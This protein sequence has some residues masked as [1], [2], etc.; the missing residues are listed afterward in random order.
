MTAK[1]FSHNPCF[2]GNSFAIEV[3]YDEANGEL[4][5]QS[6]FQWKLLCNQVF[7]LKYVGVDLSQ[8]LFQWKLLCNMSIVIALMCMITVTILVL[9]ETPLQFEA[10]RIGVITKKKSQSLFQWKLLC[11]SGKISLFLAITCPEVCDFKPQ[12]AYL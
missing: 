4:P 11:N 1:R 6:L 9:V 3:V 5:S 8:S 10:N 7:K 2:S 12:C